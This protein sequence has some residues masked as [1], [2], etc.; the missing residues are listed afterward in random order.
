MSLYLF[1]GDAWLRERA[2]AQLKRKLRAQS[3]RPWI[4]ARFDGEAL[5]IE[6][7]VESLQSS[8]LFRENVLV[9]VKRVDKLRDPEALLPYLERPLPPERCIILEGERLD[10]RGKLPQLVLRLGEV[11]D[12]PPP[13]RRQLPSLVHEL[14]E[15]R[16]LR[17]SPQ[18]LRH[19]LESVEEDLFR[20][21]SEVEK[22]SL[23]LG[24]G[25]VSPADLDGILFHD[26]GGDVFRCLDALIERRLEALSLLRALWERGA[27]P[28]KV[29]FLLASQVRA[30]LRVRSLMA[31]GLSAH[32]IAQRTGDYPWLVA[33]RI[34]TAQ[35]LTPQELRAFLQRL[36]QE[37]LQIKRGARHPEE[38]VWALALK[39][40]FSRSESWQAS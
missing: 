32:E 14:L 31:E 12:H 40:V 13:D 21:E 11:H 4:E 22:L 9:H 36:H 24:R 25:E 17:L 15:E 30:L 35:R 23:Y 38:A 6:Q 26:R 20:L 37:D 19:L 10:R 28:N 16:G 1:T 27:E 18:G 34:K 33:K 39:W 7:F 2:I 5:P 8:P 29:F 3:Q